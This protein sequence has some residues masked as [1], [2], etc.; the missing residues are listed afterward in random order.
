[1]M[2]RL[3]LWIVGAVLVA[4][5]IGWMIGASGR[6]ERELAKRAAELRA[7]VFDVRAKVLDGRVALFENNFGQ[8][9]QLFAE[10]RTL[11]EQRQ[12]MLREEGDAEQAGQLEVTLGHL[13]E[14]QRL[15][16]SLD[17]GAHKEAT[18]ALRTLS[19]AR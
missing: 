9:T 12:T 1:M 4:F 14:A 13:R 17:H 19:V 16:V 10:A 5:G 18:Q 11:L 3:Y 7:D 8:A 6:S 2:N 15:A